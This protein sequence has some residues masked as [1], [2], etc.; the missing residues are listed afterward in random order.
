MSKEFYVEV[1]VKCDRTSKVMNIA[2]SLEEAGSLQ[3][4]KEEREN[5]G[6]EILDFLNGVPKPTPDLVVMFRG[7]IVVLPT[8]VV[9]K[10]DAAVLRLLHDLTQSNAFPKPAVIPRK[11]T[12]NSGKRESTSPA[13][14]PTPP[15]A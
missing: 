9:K 1:P 8:V 14:S 10:D 15:S 2:I 12:E 4:F 13:A 3:K 6:R 5:S 11:K 7:K